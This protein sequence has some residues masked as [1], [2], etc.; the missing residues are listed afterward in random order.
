MRLIAAIMALML[1]AFTSPAR[2]GPYDT[3]IGL[4]ASP[5]CS[6]CNVTIGV[7][8]TKPIYLIAVM[9]SEPGFALSGAEMRVEGLPGAWSA[10]PVPNP[11]ANI[12]LGN[13]FGDG[14]HIA[15]WPLPSGSCILLYTVWVTANTAVSDVTLK[16]VRHTTPSNPNFACPRVFI[17]CGSCDIWLCSTGGQMFVNSDRTCNVGTD[18]R[19]WTGIKYIYR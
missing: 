16:V 8:E 6:S 13:P 11:Q 9:Q 19:T 4:F 10:V 18:A 2:S 1:V 17:E 5:D 15:F 14:A 7:G 3:S 12:V